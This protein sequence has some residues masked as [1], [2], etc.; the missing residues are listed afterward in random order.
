MDYKTMLDEV[1]ND[2][3]AT[4][5]VKEYQTPETLRERCLGGMGVR[6]SQWLHY[7]GLDI[8]EVLACALEDANHPKAT[9]VFDWI[10]EATNDT[11]G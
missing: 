4:V 8:M 10:E 2:A 9:I 7:D 3:A 6:L 5:F 11:E 1:A